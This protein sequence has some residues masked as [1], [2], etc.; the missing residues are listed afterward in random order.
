MSNKIV[1]SVDE[2]LKLY[3]SGEY[4][5]SNLSFSNP[6]MYNDLLNECLTIKDGFSYKIA[7][8]CYY[9]GK[10]TKQSDFFAFS[11]YK[12]GALLGDKTCIYNLGFCYYYGIGID[13]NFEEAVKWYKE[14]AKQ[15]Y[16]LSL[17][18]LGLCY[19]YGHGVEVDY[20]KSFELVKRAADDNYPQAMSE[21]G[22]MYILGEYVDFDSELGYYYAKA[23][24]DLN[25]KYGLYYTGVCYE[26]GV[27]I[28]KNIEIAL[29]YYE[30]A[31]DAGLAEAKFNFARL[32]IEDGN[33]KRRSYSEVKKL[34]FEA[35]ELGVME[36]R[37]FIEDLASQ[38]DA[39]AKE[40]L[41]NIYDE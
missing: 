31:S 8:L 29:D 1:N 25:N 18:A 38:G 19:R 21:L 33:F 7:G 12:E 17:Y 11:C 37:R 16:S 41:N 13:M 40:F 26:N 10:G 14:A 2:Y 4:N 27:G 23:S 22:R 20:N 6:D 36:A 28:N 34:I 39:D 5:F 30:K 9:Y 15:N 35:E 3:R 32:L 24:A